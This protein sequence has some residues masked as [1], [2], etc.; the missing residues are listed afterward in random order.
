VLRCRIPGAY[1]HAASAYGFQVI[2]EI[3]RQSANISLDATEIISDTQVINK[4][5]TMTVA[6]TI[7]H[8]LGGNKF[9]AMTGANSFV[10]CGRALQF[11]LPKAPKN[12]ANLVRIELSPSDEYRLTFYRHRGPSVKELSAIPFVQVSQLSATFRRETGLELA[13]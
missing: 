8:Q 2:Q 5:L 13:L 1:F 4:G 11:R 9:V 7:L 10:D 6:Q 3:N 12:G